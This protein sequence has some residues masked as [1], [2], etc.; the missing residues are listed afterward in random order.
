MGGGEQKVPT[1]NR[2]HIMFQTNFNFTLL[3]G[4]QKIMLCNTVNKCERVMANLWINDLFKTESLS[5]FAD[6]SILF[7]M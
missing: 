1:H 3:F 6:L 7:K 4:I 2:C 5:R